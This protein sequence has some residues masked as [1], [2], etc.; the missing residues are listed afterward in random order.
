MVQ[1]NCLRDALLQMLKEKKKI[2][3][4]FQTDLNEKLLMITM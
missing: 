3:Q 4:L 2:Q 1:S